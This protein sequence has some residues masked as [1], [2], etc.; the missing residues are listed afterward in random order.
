MSR[1]RIPYAAEYRQQM[2]DLVR[3]GRSPDHLAR[4]FEPSAQSIRNWVEQAG[5]EEGRRSDGTTTAEREELRR[6]Q[7]EVRRQ[8]EE[9]AILAKPR[10]GS[11]GRRTGRDLPVH[12]S[13]PGRVPHCD[14]GACSA[15]PRAGTTLG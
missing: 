14:H 1:K 4:E 3:S 15:S 2:V 6:L 10:P 5:R 8:R 7:R 13:E 11:L 9:R 12:E